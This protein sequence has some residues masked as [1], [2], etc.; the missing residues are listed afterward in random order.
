MA[1]N[2]RVSPANS[3]P[4]RPLVAPSHHHPR[5]QPTLPLPLLSASFPACPDAKNHP[6]SIRDIKLANRHAHLEFAVLVRLGRPSNGHQSHACI[7]RQQKTSVVTGVFFNDGRCGCV[8]DPAENVVRDGDI[9]IQGPQ[10]A[11]GVMK[12]A[13]IRRAQSTQWCGTKHPNATL[14][15]PEQQI[16]RRCIQQENRPWM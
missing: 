13:K 15:F 5:P 7:T 3:S 12:H 14:G 4:L 10:A 1:R 8:Q 16:L 6:Q 2:L 11:R 9:G